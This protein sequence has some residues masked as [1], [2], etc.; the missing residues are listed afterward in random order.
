[1]E[2]HFCER[3]ITHYDTFIHT[4]C[5]VPWAL[6][7]LSR[8]GMRSMRCPLLTKAKCLRLLPWSARLHEAVL[9]NISCRRWQRKP[10][11]SLPSIGSTAVRLW[12]REMRGAVAE[13]SLLPSF[14]PY[15]VIAKH[16]GKLQYFLIS[17]A[18]PL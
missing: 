13:A 11:L 8:G 16:S 15:D 5:K 18:F 1:M 4:G 6:R 14:L 2:M 10:Y 9:R 7:G 17:D 12:R 3:V